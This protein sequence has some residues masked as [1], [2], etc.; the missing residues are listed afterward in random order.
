MSVY[1]KI[2]PDKLR[3]VITDFYR[4]LFDDVMIGFMFIGKD[5]RRLIEKEIEL[6]SRFLGADIRYTGRPMREAHGKLPIMGGHFDRRRKILEET[7]A[8]HD[9]DADVREAWIRHTVALREQVTA[10]PTGACNDVPASRFTGAP[11]GP[12]RGGSGGA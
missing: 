7:L 2:G 3:A 8:A 12:E 6:T 1:D 11:R 10:D 5:R 9:V 4:R